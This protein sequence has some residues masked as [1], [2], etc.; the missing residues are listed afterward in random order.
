MWPDW[1]TALKEP[2]CSQGQPSGGGGNDGENSREGDLGGKRG[3]LG[4][5]AFPPLVIC[6]LADL[7]PGRIQV[8]LMGHQWFFCNLNSWD[9]RNR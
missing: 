3:A 8:G 1:K 5:T 2:W 6:S 9:S 4:L 7:G